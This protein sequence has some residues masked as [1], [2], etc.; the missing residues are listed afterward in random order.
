[1][2]MIEVYREY[3]RIADHYIPR[4]CKDALLA[5]EAAGSISCDPPAIERPCYKGVPTLADWVRIT[6]P[7]VSN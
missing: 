6:F 1:M 4:N 3:N 7:P 2:A 5:L